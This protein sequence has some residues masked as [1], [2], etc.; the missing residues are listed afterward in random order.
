MSWCPPVFNPAGVLKYRELFQWLPVHFT[1]K[2]TPRREGGRRRVKCDAR[3]QFPGKS[4]SV[5]WKYTKP[6]GTFFFMVPRLHFTLLTRES[7]TADARFQS[8]FL[9]FYF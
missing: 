8:A 4:V 7:E 2:Q 6:P 1:S 5:T 9:A 3:N